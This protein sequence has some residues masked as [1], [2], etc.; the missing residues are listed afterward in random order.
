MSL[1]QDARLR[2]NTSH[3]QKKR[4]SKSVTSKSRCI[5]KLPPKAPS[6]VYD[7]FKYAFFTKKLRYTNTLVN[8]E[9]NDASLEPKL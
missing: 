6:Q 5:L 2:P 7:S 9:L 8:A 1:S 3:S 4:K